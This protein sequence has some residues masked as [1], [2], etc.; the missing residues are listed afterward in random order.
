MPARAWAA[1]P[2]HRPYLGPRLEPTHLG[3]THLG[4]TSA[5]GNPGLAVPGLA[6]P[7]LAGPGTAV[8]PP[9]GPPVMTSL[10]PD[11]VAVCARVKGR[12][13]QRQSFPGIMRSTVALR[14]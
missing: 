1:S 4:P 13:D 3:P 10:G 7:G 2:P 8:G 9:Q 11:R 14:L 12:G 6:V 5:P